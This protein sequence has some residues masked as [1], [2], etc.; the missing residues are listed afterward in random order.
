MTTAAPERAA[1]G[2]GVGEADLIVDVQGAS[3][4]FRVGSEDVWAVRE[5]SLQIRRG[6]FV[7][8]IGRSGSGKT[9]LLNLVAGLDRP[10]SGAVRIDGDEITRYTERQLTQM[11]R[12]KVGFVFQSFGLL[13][14]LSAYENVEL[15]LR[16][17]GAG[18]RERRRRT[19]ELLEAVGLAGRARH[20]P[21]ELS[22]GEQQR[23]A[24]A[25]ALANEPALILAD[26]PTGEL[27]SST[28]VSIF[29][30]LHELVQERGVTILTTT[31]DRTV[32]ELV[33][34]VEEMRDGRLLE[35]EEQELF[36]YTVREARSQFA[37][38]LPPDVQ[39]EVAATAAHRVDFAPDAEERMAAMAAAHPESSEAAT[40]TAVGGE[41][42]PEARA[43]A[44]DGEAQTF[45]PPPD[46]ARP[47]WRPREE[48]PAAA[49]VAEESAPESDADEAAP[50]AEAEDRAEPPEPEAEADAEDAPAGAAE[51]DEEAEASAAPA[52]AADETAPEAR[53]DEAEPAVDEADADQPAGESGEIDEAELEEAAVVEYPAEA[54]EALED[55]GA[56]ALVEE[57]IDAAEPGEPVGD[58]DGAD[59]VPDAD[60]DGAVSDDGEAVVGEIDEP[61]AES[62]EPRPR[63]ELADEIDDAADEPR[64]LPD[65]NWGKL[66]DAEDAA[67]AAEPPAPMLEERSQWARPQKRGP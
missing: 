67:A 27:D 29:T 28:A 54:V 18:V 37:A 57:E 13:P 23:V 3:R 65:W 48:E 56:E 15:S 60:A 36:R 11:R 35:P 1:A 59:E 16:I 2:V 45:A 61:L 5:V 49:A 46:V 14:L 66:P 19:D 63:D 25:R 26:E 30:L 21:Y 42:A 33:P 47:E 41:P 39:E 43:A 32:M 7:V 9:T 4:S 51:E 17:A 44:A 62:A 50:P 12:R 22:G 31:H 10:T 55:D 20:R 53:E 34:R 38:E 6:E 64:E 40:R 24:I 58:L 52:E 8:L